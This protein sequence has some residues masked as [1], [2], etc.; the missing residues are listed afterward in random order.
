M[1][2]G[3]AVQENTTYLRGLHESLRC[4][5]HKIELTLERQTDKMNGGQEREQ[6]NT[7]KHRAGEGAE[8][9]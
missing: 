6:G 1:V 8:L 4:D 7:P 2:S 3:K 9:Q 5:E